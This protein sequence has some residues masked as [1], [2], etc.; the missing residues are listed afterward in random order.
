M[1]KVITKENKWKKTLKEDI[2]RN[3]SVRTKILRK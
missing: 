1:E 2:L 3:E